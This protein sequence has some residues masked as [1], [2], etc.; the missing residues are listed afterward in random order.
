MAAAFKVEHVAETPRGWRVRTVKS[1][2]H[3]VRV[4]FPPG[5]RKK[6]GG[7]VV[8]ILHPKAEKNPKCSVSEKAKK[9]P[10]ELLI[11][12]NPQHGTS[13][14]KPDCKCVICKRTRGENSSRQESLRAARERAER[15][16]RARLHP[17]QR[18]NTKMRS[19]PSEEKEAV[20]LFE[21]FHGKDAK[22]IIEKQIS[23]A[24]RL[25]YTAIGPLIAIGLDHCGLTGNKLVTQWDR[26]PYLK[27]TGVTLASA[28][29]G[30][31][32]YAIGGHLD[33]NAAL[34]HFEGVDPSKDLIDLGDAKFVV[35]E[36]RKHPNFELTEYVHRFG[37]EGGAEPRVIFNKL[38]KQIFFAGGKYFI[39]TSKGLSPGIQN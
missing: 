30:K 7:K 18:T 10:A 16:R 32:L 35:Y 21:S 24:T 33:L 26:C 17:T 27:F 22:E 9:N 20:R 29:N 11:F 1:K 14:H 3:R 23:A 4:A 6:G 5:P 36:A 31:Q 19:N 13:N 8:E 28:P 2:E 39:D 34:K 37:E 25:D 38:Q 15:I 12:G